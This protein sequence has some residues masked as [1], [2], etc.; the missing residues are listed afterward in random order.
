MNNILLI[1]YQSGWYW[2][3]WY[4][5]WSKLCSWCTGNICWSKRFFCNWWRW[6]RFR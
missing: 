6:W 4:R 1:L 5:W 3:R 2:W